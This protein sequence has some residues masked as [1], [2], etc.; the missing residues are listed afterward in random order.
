MPV[1]EFERGT[2]ENKTKE[3]VG[4]VVEFLFLSDSEETF[5]I[6]ETAFKTREVCF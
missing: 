2:A 1:I 6:I 3:T 5:W 4:V